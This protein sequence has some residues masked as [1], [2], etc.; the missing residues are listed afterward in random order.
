MQSD[1]TSTYMHWNGQFGSLLFYNHWEYMR[2]E[3][4]ARSAIYPLVAGLNDW[5]AC[6][7]AKNVTDPET[8]AY[9][10]VD[11]RA[12]NPDEALE[13]QRVVNPQMALAMAGR[14]LT[15]QRD[16]GEA[17]GIPPP[18]Y[19]SDLL[20][21]TSAYNT[22]P[23]NWSWADPA[24]RSFTLFN[25]TRCFNDVSGVV[26]AT[27]PENCLAFC[28]NTLGCTNFSWS[29]GLQECWL[30]D[31]AVK[32]PACN[33]GTAGYL[34]GRN[35]GPPPNVTEVPVW[36][37]YRGASAAQSFFIGV[38]YS[39]WP[40][41]HLVSQGAPLD[42]ATMAIAQ[43]TSRAFTVWA[44]LWK[45][46]V[47]D[48]FA[49]AVMA[50]WGA[51][52]GGAP[53]GSVEACGAPAPAFAFSPAEVLDGLLAQ[54]GSD[55]GGIPCWGPNLLIYAPGGGVENVGVSAAINA[56]L[57]GSVGGV[58]GYLQVFPFWPASESANF[59]RLLGKGGFEVSAAFDAAA[60][61]VASPVLV[62]SRYSLAESSRVALR[63]PWCAA[64]DSELAVTC[65]GTETA[66]TWNATART[67]LWDAPVGVDCEV[68]WSS[69]AT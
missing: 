61:R 16:I 39:V 47:V 48:M 63:S 67:L 28:A 15:M 31:A 65:G 12:K 1:D 59:T 11:F 19:L 53:G 62:T 33:P 66:F 36:A 57:L 9:E 46:R 20:A 56:M 8:G 54:L 7:F 10:W 18:P 25:N 3:S 17:L 51:S 32:T 43:A 5:F 42:A 23:W 68:E 34:S 30:Y 35:D 2:N 44:G 50:G 38:W 24:T 13:G 58:G 45:G 14:T 27:S 29:Y 6:Y 22:A 69:P 52:F 49:A 4:F 41:E 60:G 37:S 26:G 64:T 55:C 40:S 21:H